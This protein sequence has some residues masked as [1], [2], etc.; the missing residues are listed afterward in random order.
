MDNTWLT[1]QQLIE[2]VRKLCLAKRSGTLFCST[3]DHNSATI[4]IE[5]G[6][7]VALGFNQGF[8]MMKG[9]AALAFIQTIQRCKISFT[10]NL[11]SKIDPGLPDTAGILRRLAISS[12]TDIL[13]GSAVQTMSP[14]SG[15]AVR[16][17]AANSPSSAALLLSPAL[18]HQLRIIVQEEAH[19]AFGPIAILLCEEHFAHAGQLR[20]FT[21]VEQLLTALA[22]NTGETARADTFRSRVLARLRTMPMAG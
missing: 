5:Y 22:L 6:Q 20:T 12:S 21:D 10:D 8:K 15:P 2:E 9:G 11:V 7:I 4:V 14:P 3:A 13:Q 17:T 18:L 1:Y 19:S 16:D